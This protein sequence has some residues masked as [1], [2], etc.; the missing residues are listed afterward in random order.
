VI[1][2]RLHRLDQLSLPGCPRV[3]VA[4][5][6][7][8]RLLGL[9]WLDELPADCGLLIPDC[10]SIHTFG[11]RFSLDVD[12]LDAEGR[13]LRHVAAVPPRRIVG[14]RAAVAVLEQRA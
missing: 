1:P 13:V 6:A 11:M 5:S 12:F 10:R 14:H 9:A 4:R 7:R 2:K 3:F 8:A